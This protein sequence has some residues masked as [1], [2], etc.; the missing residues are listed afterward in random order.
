MRRIFLFLALAVLPF[1]AIKSQPTVT[2]SKDFNPSL[3]LDVDVIC[4][5]FEREAP[6]VD[7]FTNE[8]PDELKP[9]I[10]G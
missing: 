1:V 9:K 6:R 4:H 2:Q 5:M 3:R 8:S 7:M 10:G